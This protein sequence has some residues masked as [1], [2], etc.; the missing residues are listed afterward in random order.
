[1]LKKVG[2]KAFTLI[3]LIVVISI[4]SILW[5][6]GYLSFS[7]YSK[8]ARDT[9]RASDVKQIENSVLLSLTKR[10]VVPEPTN[11]K[12]I[13]Y[14]WWTLF[15]QW[16]FWRSTLDNVW[17]LNKVP[18]DPL[19]GNEYTFSISSTR[20]SY[21][22]WAILEWTK[23]NV[24]SPAIFDKTH[25]VVTTEIIPY[26]K[27]NYNWQIVHT[28]TWWIVY[29][30][31]IPSL[32]LSDTSDTNVLNVWDKIIY[33]WESWVPESYSNLDIP[34]V[35]SFSFQP[36]LVYTWVTL[37]RTPTTLKPLVK[38]LQDSML[39]TILFSHEDYQELLKIDIDNA[40]ELQLYW[41]NYI[42]D[43]LGWRFESVYFSSCKEILW[44]PWSNQWS[45]LYTISP[46]WVS[47]IEV[48]CDMEMDW[49]WW[50]RIRAYEYWIW[51]TDI[52]TVNKTRAITWNELVA[53]YTR[54]WEENKWKKF[55]IYYDKFEVTQYDET[56][57]CW[58]HTTISDLISQIT[59]WYWWDCSRSWYPSWWWNRHNNSLESVDIQVDDL[60]WVPWPKTWTGFSDDPC[61]NNGHKTTDRNIS[62]TSNGVVNHRVDSSTS[63]ISL[64]W[65][66]SPRC[67][68]NSDWSKR[69]IINEV[70]VR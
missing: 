37:P 10:W 47:K 48:Y 17:R 21:Q 58:T 55:W 66:S 41:I 12:N 69:F 2:K 38:K 70:Y 13:T 42:N 1:M 31:A 52:K 53:V 44:Y 7:W 30:V 28:S 3:E 16:T 67:A 39:W 50:T 68:W 57:F 9:T 11:P 18:L 34:T 64:G 27:W 8:D 22:V 32:I 20:K 51:Y 65:S 29:V 62:W 24:S 25:A 19:F 43:K 45:W 15:K 49:W 36:V 40:D 59:S 60:W 56:W 33:N 46:D 63:I 6:I 26:V 4:L 35:W 23:V 14:S 61:I 54:A 5:T